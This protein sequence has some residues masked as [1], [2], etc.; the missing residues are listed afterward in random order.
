MKE[1]EAG[2]QVQVQKVD[3]VMRNKFLDG[4]NFLPIALGRML[5]ESATKTIIVGKFSLSSIVCW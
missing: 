5:P 3:N 2:E 1:V 4:G